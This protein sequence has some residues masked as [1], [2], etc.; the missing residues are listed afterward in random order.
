LITFSSEPV[1]GGFLKVEVS[2]FNIHVIIPTK[3]HSKYHMRHRGKERVEKGNSLA[4]V[5]YK[6]ALLKPKK[7]RKY[8]NGCGWDLKKGSGWSKPI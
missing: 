2:F 6:Q 5:T 8:F 3:S 7:Y 1:E 4:K